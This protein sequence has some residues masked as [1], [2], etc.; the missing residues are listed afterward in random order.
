MTKIIITV[1]LS[2]NL[3][4][5]SCAS[6]NAV[7]N[8]VEQVNQ[9]TNLTARTKETI[10]FENALKEILKPEYRQPLIGTGSRENPQELSDARK[11]ILLPAAIDLLKAAEKSGQKASVEPYGDRDAT[12]NLAMKIYIQS[13]GKK[14]NL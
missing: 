2:S 6:E 7:I 10:N 1:L 5:T 8:S 9:S 14:T 3:F 11:Q 12:I 13:S 4:I